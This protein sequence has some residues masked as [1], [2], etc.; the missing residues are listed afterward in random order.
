M[1]PGD[2]ILALV[3]EGVVSVEQIEALRHEYGLD[4]PLYVQYTDTLKRLI[5]LDLGTSFHT[6]QRVVDMVLAALPFSIQLTLIAMAIAATVGILAG[7]ASAVKHNT[8]LDTSFMFLATV[9]IAAPDFWLGLMLVF[10]FVLQLGWFPIT[11][12]SLNWKVVALPAVT[13]AVRPMA[14]IARLTR[15]SV[16]EVLSE[17]YVV[18]ARSKGLAERTIRVRHVLR[19]ALIPVVTIMGIDLAATLSNAM[20]IE[21]VFAR[22]GLGRLV[23]TSIMHK[24]FPAIQSSVMLISMAYVLANLFVDICYEYLDPRIRT[25]AAR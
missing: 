22:P 2:P 20:I 12:V 4:Q 5:T 7:I 8:W 6:G 1:A 23:L 19:N 11:E 15:A 3:E 14:S 13:L 9:G 16:L 17:P 24:D 10:L 25:V 18:T 21:V